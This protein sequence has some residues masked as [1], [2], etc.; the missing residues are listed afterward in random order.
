ML[1]V[2][3]VLL[4]A[5]YFGSQVLAAPFFPNY[6]WLTISASELGSPRSTQPW[7]LNGGAVVTGLMGL[8]GAAG[9]GFALPLVGVNRWLAWLLAFCVLSIGLSA[10]WAGMHPMP[11]PKHNPGALG[12]G[13]FGAPFAAAM[14]A[15]QIKPA[16]RL[17]FVLLLNLL[18]FAACAH[19]L[20]GNAG[21][22]LNTHGGLFQKIVAA[23]SFFPSAL[24]AWVTLKRQAQL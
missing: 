21:I 6:S 5:A 17:R 18:L 2:L 11:H 24:I 4:P 22:N 13:L 7:I 16:T 19:V 12:I 23:V 8:L 14:V 20:S 15:W 1:L 10:L 9:L 3:V